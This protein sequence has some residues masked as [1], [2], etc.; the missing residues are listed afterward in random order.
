MSNT[1]T[2]MNAELEDKY[3]EVCANC[4]YRF[5][6]HSGSYGRCVNEQGEFAGSNF[7]ASS[8]FSSDRHE[9]HWELLAAHGW[10]VNKNDPNR[11]F[12]EKRALGK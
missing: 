1:Y 3:N 12:M 11:R 4:G 6:E 7:L 5:G 8:V 10:P 9:T 2:S